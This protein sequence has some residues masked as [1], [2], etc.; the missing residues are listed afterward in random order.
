MSASCSAVRLVSLS[1]RD[2][3]LE[4]RLLIAISALFF[5][6]LFLDYFQKKVIPRLAVYK[7]LEP[8]ICQELSMR[9]LQ[10]L[11]GPIVAIS[12][13]GFLLY[14]VLSGCNAAEIYVYFISG[15]SFV[16]VDIHETV[17]RWPLR[18]S[19]LAHHVMTFAIAL[20]FVEF[21]VLPP[22]D[23]KI[24]AWTTTF[25]LTNIGLMWTVDFYH[26]IY[27]TSTNLPLIKMLRKT[28]LW[29]APV[30]IINI[31]LLML[32]SIS[33]AIGGVW[34][35]FVCLLFMTLAYAYNS[36][37]AI[38][39]MVRFDCDRYYKS[40]QGR[41]LTKEEGPEKRQE[42]RQSRVASVLFI[43]LIGQD[44]TVSI[45]PGLRGDLDTT[46]RGVSSRGL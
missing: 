41:W 30:R 14:Q 44:E 35:A 32:G 6:N 46:E 16:A 45:L 24:I 19:L 33:S 4:Y 9:M 2:L 20:A 38:T 40:H 21:Q 25:F 28:Y 22:N 34:F 10:L 29:F 23:E 7:H 11:L 12:G 42:R 36:Y 27:R 43:P 39:F 37:K 15:I 18:A 31:V 8:E 3:W 5:I 13:L 17:R 1:A 26:V